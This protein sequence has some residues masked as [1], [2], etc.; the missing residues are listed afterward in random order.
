MSVFMGIMV[1]V[2]REYLVVT[3]AGAIPQ[4]E[5]SEP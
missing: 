4:K 1:G 2:L 3:I 5:L